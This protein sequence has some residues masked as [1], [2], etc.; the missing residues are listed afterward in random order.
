MPSGR[1]SREPEEPQLGPEDFRVLRDAVSGFCGLELSL[2]QRASVER[3]LRERLMLLGLDSFTE[4]VRLLR[5][6]PQPRGGRSLGDATTELDEAV[7]CLTTHETYFNREAYQ[8]RAFRE[9]VI[10]MLAKQAATRK[11]LAVWS[12]GCSTGEEVYTIAAMLLEAPELVG[13]DLLV[14]GSDISR[15]CL[16]HA[17]RGVYGPSAFRVTP[18]EFRRRWFHERESGTVVSDR[19]RQI[20]HFGHLNLLEPE[21]ATAVGRVDAVFCRNVLIYLES[22]A[23][24]RVIDLFHERLYP[25]GVLLLGHSES[26]LNVSTA[27]ELLHLRDDLVYRR[28]LVGSFGYPSS[29]KM[30]I[31]AKI[32][33]DAESQDEPSGAVD[34]RKTP[35]K[36][37]EP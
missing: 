19:L 15:R 2:E 3:R 9:E 7:E 16:A 20:C 4:Y 30:R 8:L 26:L 11:R 35:G 36:K 37:S 13:F 34:V 24:R 17:R 14:Y 22:R 33:I 12:A 18:P 27:F 6:E 10:P 23:R 1:G 25:G 29:R 31:A 32:P 5:D 21:R 28:P